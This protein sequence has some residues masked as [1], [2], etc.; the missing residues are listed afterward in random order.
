MSYVQVLTGAT[1]ALGAHLLS[2]LGQ[3]SEHFDV[4]A[5]VRAEDDVQAKARIEESLRTRKL[6]SMDVANGFQNGSRHVYALAANLA[7]DNL[8]LTD[9]AYQKLLERT[10]LVF[11]VGLLS[12]VRLP[13]LICKQIAWPVNFAYGLESFVPILRG[14]QS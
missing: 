6:P 1:G 12:Q 7:I 13:E 2:L 3:M 10:F 11:H 14:T 5:L 9:E 8:G 4:A